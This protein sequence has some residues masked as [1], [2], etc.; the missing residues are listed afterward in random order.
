MLC[1]I[2]KAIKYVQHGCKASLTYVR[3]VAMETPEIKDVPVVWEFADVF[4]D[5]LPGIPQD[6]EVEF[7][8]DLVSGPSQ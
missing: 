2:M 1:S 7:R 8:I 5:D 6:R 4:L 3:D